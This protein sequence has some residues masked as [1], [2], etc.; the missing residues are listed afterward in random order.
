MRREWIRL[1]VEREMWGRCRPC[2]E[3]SEP[4][5]RTGTAAEAESGKELSGCIVPRDELESG[6]GAEKRRRKV[7]C[8]SGEDRRQVR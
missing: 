1:E 8:L 7:S 3:Q 4:R 5:G 2:W 6:R